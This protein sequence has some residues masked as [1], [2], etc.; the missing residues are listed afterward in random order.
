MWKTGA[1]P[2]RMGLAGPQACVENDMLVHRLFDTSVSP[3]LS[4]GRFL[5]FH[6]DMWKKF[7][8]RKMPA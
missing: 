8:C 1:K 2:R 3:D 5:L 4:T 7:G 6:V